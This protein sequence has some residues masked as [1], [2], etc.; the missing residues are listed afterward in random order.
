MQRFLPVQMNFIKYFYDV[1]GLRSSGQVQ[2]VQEE[3]IKPTQL[4]C[5]PS[6]QICRPRYLTILS[7]NYNAR[8]HPG[9][10][11]HSSLPPAATELVSLTHPEILFSYH[12]F[13]CLGGHFFPLSRPIIF[14]FPGKKSIYMLFNNKRNVKKKAISL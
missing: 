10:I 5:V 2:C 3:E 13:I 14:Y 7:M 1:R 12:G 11:T 6:L 8:I 9:L 4:V